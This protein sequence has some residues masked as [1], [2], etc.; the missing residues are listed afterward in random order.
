MKKCEAAIGA[1]LLAGTI[2]CSQNSNVSDQ[3]KQSGHSTYM[4]VKD[5]VKH[6]KNM[7]S[8]DIARHLVHVAEKVPNV[9]QA[10][11]IVTLGYAVVGINV[12]KNASQR[13]METIKKSVTK[14]LK[15]DPYG[16]NAAVVVDPNAVQR[17][18]NMKKS[19]KSGQPVSGIL[20][21]LSHI[22]NSVKPQV[23][24]GHDRHH[25]NRMEQTTEKGR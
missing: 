6:P 7:S 23:K 24:P 21:E 9:H 8:Q 2:G 19:I 25:P 5:Q 10:T 11:A 16:G 17:I 1:L 13:E 15:K 4:K 22:I 18:K 20:G 12:D 3:P 14:A